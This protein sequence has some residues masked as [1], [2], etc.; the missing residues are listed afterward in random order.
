MMDWP[1]KISATLFLGGCTFDCPYCHNA[2][3]RDARTGASEVWEPLVRHLRDKRSWLDGVVVTGGE[4]TDD[5]DLPSL[6]AALAEEDLSVKLDT[7][8]ANPGV[9]AHLLA[10]DLVASVAMDI[11]TTWERYD[12]VTR[13]PGM[14]RRVAESAGTLLG[15]GVR[16]EFR[17]TLF[18][19]VVS[20]DDVV[21]IA[22]DLADGDLYAL[23][24]YRSERTLDPR[25]AEISAYLPDHILAATKR[26]SEHLPTIVRGL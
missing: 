20:L 16:H 12:E 18:P 3:L 11:K 6:L 15:S 26:C 1:G 25:A 9:L 7:N 22:E 13:T 4:P 19:G 23:Q 8:G 17:T 21:R 2:D 14:V 5:P 10:E 24:Q